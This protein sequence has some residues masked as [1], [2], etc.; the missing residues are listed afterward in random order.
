MRQPVV[1][2]RHQSQ[3]DPILPGDYV[4]VGVN[5]TGVGMSE[6][7]QAKVFDPFFTTKPIGKGTGL[8]LSMVYGFVRQSGGH[9]GFS[10]QI[11]G[12]NDSDAVSAQWLS[13]RRRRLPRPTTGHGGAAQARACWSL[14][15]T[16]RS[17]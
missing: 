17:K 13:G 10:S 2:D 12:G 3:P 11:R 8:G 1:L 7:V 9:V 5:D 16:P 15:T 14:R 6:S 4:V